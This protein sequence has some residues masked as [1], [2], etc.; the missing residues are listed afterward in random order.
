MRSSGVILAK[1]TSCLLSAA[2]TVILLSLLEDVF[3]SNYPGEVSMITALLLATIPLISY[4]FT[5]HL[6]N[7]VMKE[8]ILQSS[9]S[10]SAIFLALSIIT[11]AFSI[12]VLVAVTD[13]LIDVVNNG[14]PSEWLRR[15]IKDVILLLSIIAFS[16]LGPFA[17]FFQLH[18]RKIF[19]SKAKTTSDKLVNSIGK[20]D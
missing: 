1:F 8:E 15:D 2:L 6:C 18:V 13:A 3:F 19:I 12:C 16:I 4:L 17:F 14:T 9:K 7:K 10:K 20:I 11:F 5:I